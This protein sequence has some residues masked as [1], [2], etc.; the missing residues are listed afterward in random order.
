MQIVKRMGNTPLKRINNNMST[1]QEWY[2]AR[3]KDSLDLIEQ[4]KI[5][6]KQLKAENDELRVINKSLK[7]ALEAAKK[8]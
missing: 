3:M 8:V 6:A 4:W 7:D 2:E 1:M 5:V